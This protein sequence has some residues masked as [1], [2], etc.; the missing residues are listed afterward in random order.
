MS[1]A[2]IEALLRGPEPG[3]QSAPTPESNAVASVTGIPAIGE[4]WAE[5]GGI[6][7]GVSRGK[8]GSLDAHIVLLDATPENDLSWAD[9]VSWAEGLGN[10]ARLPT[11]FESAL[12]YAN[13]RDKLDTE[14]WHWTGTQ[15]LG[16]SAFGQYFDNGFQ[17]YYGKKSKGRARAV[18]R[19]SI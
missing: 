2:F 7:A 14:R 18:R 13:L 19:V 1:R 3:S 8:D 17:D 15:F 16:S 10:D 11:R 5:Q 9:A 12:L 6:Y 4:I